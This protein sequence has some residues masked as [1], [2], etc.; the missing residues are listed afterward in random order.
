MACFEQTKRSIADCQSLYWLRN[1]CELFL[2][3][4]ASDYGMGAYLFQK[5]AEGKEWPVHFLSQS[6]TD[7]QARWST[8]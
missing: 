6:F 2:H 8:L 1:D 7:V 4:D 3:T 5:D